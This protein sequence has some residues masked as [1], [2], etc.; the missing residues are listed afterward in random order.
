MLIGIAIEIPFAIGEMILGLEAYFVR[1]WKTLQIVAYL[2]LIGEILDSS[3]YF[4]QLLTTALLGLYF[5]VPESVRWLIGAGKIEEAKKIVRQAARVNGKE[6]PE[7][8]LK[9]ADLF[10]AKIEENKTKVNSTKKATILD[11]FR[12]TKMALRSINMGFQVISQEALRLKLNV[13]I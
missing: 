5:C 7:H 10:S 3:I 6:A 8:L 2:P 12:P 1:D 13:L 11:L 4:S 9:A